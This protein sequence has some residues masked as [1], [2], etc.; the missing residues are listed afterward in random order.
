MMSWNPTSGP[1]YVT[2]SFVRVARN[3]P[4]ARSDTSQIGDNVRSGATS[5]WREAGQ[6]ILGRKTFGSRRI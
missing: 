6:R 1:R 4:R 2:L 3:L 5:V